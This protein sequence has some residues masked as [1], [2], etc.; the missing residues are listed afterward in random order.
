MKT[1]LPFAF[2][3]LPICDLAAQLSV[4]V[5]AAS[6]V[7]LASTSP[8][9][10]VGIPEGADASSLDLQTSGFPSA[11][12][13]LVVH[14]SSTSPF[15]ATAQIASHTLV[16]SGDTETGTTPSTGG[17]PVYGPIELLVRFR[18]TPGTTGRVAVSFTRNLYPVS[19]P[20][21]TSVVQ[22]R[23]DMGD[24]GRFDLTRPSQAVFP[25]F[26]GP[27]GEIVARV[28]LENHAETSVTLINT[29]SIV[30]NYTADPPTTCTITR[31]GPGCG[32]AQSNGS[33]LQ[34]GTWRAIALL[35]NGNF[36]GAPA[37]SA[38]GAHDT[39]PTLPGGCS[40]LTD[41]AAP[42]ALVSDAFGYVSHTVTV[43]AT[44]AGTIYHQFL[45]IEPGTLAIRAS[46]GLAISC[47]Q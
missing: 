42:F 18:T 24:D 4:E 12:A 37:I 7:G 32:G 13:R 40:L 31:Y 36:A 5:S 26:A 47:M 19:S 33:S 15:A 14:A 17:S 46:N 35:G 39:G 44:A 29:S 41:G 6:A 11:G 30:L 38:F 1:A 8:A 9:S 25:V 23:V 21:A 27:S 3:C 20:L 16:V 22:G 2:A 45:S 28:V 43:P 10:F 34:L